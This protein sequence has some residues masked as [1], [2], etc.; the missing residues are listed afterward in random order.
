MGKRVRNSK[1]GLNSQR[2][3]SGRKTLRPKPH[4]R[5]LDYPH[6]PMY[7]PPTSDETTAEKRQREQRNIIRK[8][9]WQNRCLATEDKGSY[10]DNIAWDEADTKIKSLIYLSLGQ[11]A[12]NIFHHRNPHTEMSKFT[13]D[14]FAEQLKE[15]FKEVRNETFDKNTTKHWRNSTQ[16]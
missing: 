8:V 3:H 13:T 6:E 1:T 11:E 9:H 4:N 5:E 16:E 15:T 10:V 12:T 2:K 14:A 7:E